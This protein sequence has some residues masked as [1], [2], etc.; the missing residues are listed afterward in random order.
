VCAACAHPVTTESARIER[1][2]RHVHTC[3]NP[4]RYVYRIG[5]FRRA[6]GCVGVGRWSGEH[7]W[8]VGYQ[9]QVACCGACSMHL[10]WAFEP[11]AAGSAA[12]PFWG[13]IVD[14]L[15]EQ[16]DPGPRA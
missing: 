10:G 3:V 9:W 13:L 12:E 5:C 4:A 15:R 6:P 11:E 7:S 2:G 8:F 14:R 16:A 1:A